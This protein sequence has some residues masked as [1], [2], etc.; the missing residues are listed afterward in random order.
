[1]ESWRLKDQLE[2]DKQSAETLFAV[3]K[4]RMSEKLSLTVF[5][6]CSS[7]YLFNFKHFYLSL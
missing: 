4:E 7:S 2:P 6:Y 3:E 5:A 1:M